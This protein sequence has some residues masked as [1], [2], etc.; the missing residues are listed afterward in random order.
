MLEKLH[1]PFLFVLIALACGI[2]GLIILKIWGVELPDDLFFKILG[3]L[4][5]LVL[6]FG[7]LTVVNSDFGEHKKLKDDNY[8]D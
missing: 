8:I 2:S 5:V 7:F 1:K 6:L 3:T 4:G